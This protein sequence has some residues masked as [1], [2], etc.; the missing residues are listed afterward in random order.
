MYRYVGLFSVL[1]AYVGLCIVV[2]ASLG[3]V[4][5]F[6]VIQHCLCLRRVIAMHGSVWLC[7]IMCCQI[8]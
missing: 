6:R 5:L 2:Y 1:Y 3:Y 8:G 7:R 4:Q